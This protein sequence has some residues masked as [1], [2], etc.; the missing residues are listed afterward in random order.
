MADYGLVPSYELPPE[1]QSV[2]DEITTSNFYPHRAEA[3]VI[4]PG[5]LNPNV[6]DT[7][8]MVWLDVLIKFT[9]RFIAGI[10]TPH[11]QAEMSTLSKASD[12]A[13]WQVE[14][15]NTPDQ[16]RWTIG[17]LQHGGMNSVA[18][19]APKFHLPRATMTLIKAATDAGWQGK[20]YPRGWYPG[21]G[22]LVLAGFDNL[23]THDELIPGEQARWVNYTTKGDVATPE[24]WATFRPELPRNSVSRM[25]ADSHCG[26]G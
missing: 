18:L 11:G 19:Y 12:W 4:F 9:H 22:K 24:Q 7:F 3:V 16:A 17:Q 15:W 6:R 8:E 26:D 20:I 14:A 21:K 25:F 13:I 2:W 1:F 10:H 23:A 5:L